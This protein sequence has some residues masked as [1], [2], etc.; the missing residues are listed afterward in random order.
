MVGGT[1]TR[2]TNG[3]EIGW[4]VA[5]NRA[6]LEGTARL[7]GGLLAEVIPGEPP[8]PADELAAELTHLRSD[9][10]VRLAL[11]VDG[12]EVVGA[13]RL[14]LGPD[15]DRGYA[16]LE[17]LVVAPAHRRR[18][19]GTRLLELVMEASRW[20]G[21][22]VIGSGGPV[23]HPAAAAF[24]E[25]VGAT[26]GLIEHQNRMVVA[27]LDRSML[28]KWVELA[29]E[30]AGDYS[31]VSFD[32]R[33]PDELV[34]GFAEL[35]A[36]MGTA[37]H[38]D[39]WQQPT[40]TPT[41]LR[42]EQ[43]AYSRKG[44]ESWTV[45]TRHDPTGELVGY[46]VLGFLPYRPW[47]GFQGDTGVEP[48]HRDHGLGRWLKATN[49]LRLLDERPHVT[50]VETWNAEVNAPMLSINHAM[51]FHPVVAWQDWELALS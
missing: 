32:G 39:A 13:A 19:I 26:R 11:A 43:D 4:V 41:M 9:Q 10:D 1:D 16:D 15:S 6:E 40:I 42:E 24:A 22:T 23:D 35:M 18:G 20:D 44:G 27:D 49:A 5:P 30:R 31:L 48:A 25:H 12:G 29:T 38:T 36:V 2:R 46:S 34:E 3:I 45:C 14:I 28:E 7:I 33:C 17:D 50:T 21:R 47:L 8:Y 51:G 37:P